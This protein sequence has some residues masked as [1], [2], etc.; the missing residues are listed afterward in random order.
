[1]VCCKYLRVEKNKTKKETGKHIAHRSMCI[2]F[3]Y[4]HRHMR[5]MGKRVE[6]EHNF[7]H[8]E[9]KNNLYTSLASTV[10]VK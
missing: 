5:V 7:F 10:Y 6:W 2:Q 1:M 4:N 9:L 3:K 8:F